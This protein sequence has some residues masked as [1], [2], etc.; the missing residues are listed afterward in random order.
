MDMQTL[1]SSAVLSAQLGA[2]TRKHPLSQQHAKTPGAPAKCIETADGL[3]SPPHG[4]RTHGGPCAMTA[5]PCPASISLG[6]GVCLY[7]QLIYMPRQAM[8]MEQ[9]GQTAHLAR[10]SP[11]FALIALL[12]W[13][14][15]ESREDKRGSYIKT[16][17]SAAHTATSLVR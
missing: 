6:R 14:R 11:R 1:L 15:Q 9:L 8:L 3:T 13:S 7:L 17:Q 16:H 2:V 12:Y 5:V 4:Q 10:P